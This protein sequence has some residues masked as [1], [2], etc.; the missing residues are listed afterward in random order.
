MSLKSAEYWKKWS[1]GIREKALI[2][3]S[4]GSVRCNRCGQSDN[5]LLDTLEE[6][7]NLSWNKIVTKYLPNSRKEKKEVYCR[8][9][10]CHYRGVQDELS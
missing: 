10:Q 7:K 3:V 5:R 6:G 9:P 2:K 8:C 4:N 1:K